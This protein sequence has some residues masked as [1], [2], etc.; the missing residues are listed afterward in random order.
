MPIDLVCHGPDGTVAELRV[1]V[2]ALAR[3]GDL[4]QALESHLGIAAG[5]LHRGLTPLADP[6]PVADTDLVDGAAVGLGVPVWPVHSADAPRAAYGALELAVVGGRHGGLA[7]PIEPGAR[8]SVGRHGGA[9]LVLA[10]PEVSREHAQVWLTEDGAVRLADSGSRNGVS[11]RGHRLA[12]E[13]EL[14]VGDVFGAGETVVGLRERVVADAD[15]VPDGGGL[16]LTRPRRELSPPRRDD[17]QVPVPPEPP[18]G[19]RVPPAAVL[20]PA[21]PGLLLCVPAPVLGGVLLA[22][23]PL[24]ALVRWVADRRSGRTEHLA[25]HRAH[26]ARRARFLTALAE[27]VVAEERR[28]RLAHP[29]PAAVVSLAC[30]PSARL[31]ERRRGDPDFLAVRVGLADRPAAVTLRP[32]PAVFAEGPVAP[33]VPPPA[34]DVPVT[35]ALPEVRVLGVACAARAAVLA[36]ARA[37]VAQVATLHAPDDLS[38]VV[39][40]GSGTAADWAWTSWLPHTTRAPGAGAATLLVVDGAHVAD[41]GLLDAGPGSERYAVV[42]ETDEHALPRECGAVLVP[43]GTAGGTRAVLRRPGRPPVPDVLVDGLVAGAAA[44]VA[45]ALAPVRLAGTEPAAPIG[46]AASPRSVTVEPRPPAELGTP[47]LGRILAGNEIPGSRP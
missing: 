17:L 10:D 38:I 24:L 7:T 37:I 28:E 47:P 21:L 12:G 32:A 35:V 4:R 29:D 33:P 20:A 5:P 14:Q 27:T 31:W 15:L 46:S 9:G 25:E 34:R 36:T 40:T 22:L 30:H 42:L 8:L 41:A 39:V 44:R 18:A 43:C 16:R 45:R 19:F 26:L 3:V 6:T 23:T 11:V 2:G 13:T 1:T